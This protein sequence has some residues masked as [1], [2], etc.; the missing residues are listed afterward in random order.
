MSL[1]WLL[2]QAHDVRLDSKAILKKT[3]E[4]E[5]SKMFNMV[6]AIGHLEKSIHEV[7]TEIK[8]EMSQ[9]RAE[10]KTEMSPR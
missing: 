2:L 6:T 10:M 5:K 4:L 7:K 3:I 9:L 1:I 8:T